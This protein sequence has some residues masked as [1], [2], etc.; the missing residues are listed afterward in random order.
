MVVVD[1]ADMLL[2]ETGQVVQ[3]AVATL[4][5]VAEQKDMLVVVV[6]DRHI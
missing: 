3:V 5:V 4:V 6:V 1:W 2:L